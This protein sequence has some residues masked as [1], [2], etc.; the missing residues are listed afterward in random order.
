MLSRSSHMADKM[1]GKM[2]N[3]GHFI[4]RW[5]PVGLHLLW[6]QMWHCWAQSLHDTTS[7]GRR[8]LLLLRLLLGVCS[9]HRRPV[10]CKKEKH[11]FINEPTEHDFLSLKRV[12]QARAASGVCNFA[13]QHLRPSSLEKGVE[14]PI[15][16][17]QSVNFFLHYFH[18]TSAQ[19]S[20]ANWLQTTL[21]TVHNF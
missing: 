16:W 8:L 5:I 11:H 21:P 9:C 14:L 20:D 4:W 3:L 2:I 15:F 1:L 17:Q 6:M 12:I 19:N 18:W 10:P 7:A 13:S